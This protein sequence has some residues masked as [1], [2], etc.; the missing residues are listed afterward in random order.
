LE[1]AACRLRSGEPETAVTILQQLLQDPLLAAL[2]PAI[3]N[4]ARLQLAR[5]LEQL[6]QPAAALP[7][8]RDRHV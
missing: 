2:K 7:K 4:D 5:I 8:L 3:L 6:Q 1:S